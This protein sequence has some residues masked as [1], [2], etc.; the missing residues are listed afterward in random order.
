MGAEALDYAAPENIFIHG[1]IGAT[2]EHNAQLYYRRAEVSRRLAG[3]VEE[4]ADCVA[5]ELLC[6]RGVSTRVPGYRAQE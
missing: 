4:A 3:G 6:A 1:G 2:W 5:E